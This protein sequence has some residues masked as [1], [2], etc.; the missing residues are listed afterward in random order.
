MCDLLKCFVSMSMLSF[1][2]VVAVL[3][4]VVGAVVVAA[5]YIVTN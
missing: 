3:V 4:P 1:S 2:V 5:V